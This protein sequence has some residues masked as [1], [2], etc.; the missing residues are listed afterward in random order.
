MVVVYGS[1]ALRKTGKFR[2]SDHYIL[3]CK[4]LPLRYSI[5]VAHISSLSL[6][7]PAV[8]L[9]ETL[10]SLLFTQYQQP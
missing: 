7:L 3:L 4:H 2:E 1:W 9:V 5:A 6:T 8:G 10:F